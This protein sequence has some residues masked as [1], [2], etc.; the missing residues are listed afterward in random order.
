MSKKRPPATITLLLVDDHPI[1]REGIKYSLA[2]NRRIRVI[3]EASNGREAIALAKKL[4]PDVILM[5]IQMPE[6]SGL[7]A[8]KHITKL[9]PK[10]KILAL[11]THD[12]REY[13]V[14][15]TK[16]GAKGY[17]FKDTP[18]SEL[19]KAIETVCSGGVHY[20]PRANQVLLE[21]LM[22]PEGRHPG[23]PVSDLT[24]REM[25]VL[26][27]L[28]SGDPAKEIAK[29]LTDSLRTIHAHK[30]H[31]ARKLGVGNIAGLTRIALREG[32]ITMDD[33][34]RGRP[35]IS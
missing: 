18:P 23:N 30:E 29:R 6:M 20:S 10:T 2:T 25:E 22:R 34:P 5:D 27:L 21:E 7:E 13:I 26:R 15:I 11:T 19:V 4:Q 12:N 32:I 35:S 8:T 31:I 17:V 3:G 28:V 16:L 9:G 14:N 24:T 33:L 1:V